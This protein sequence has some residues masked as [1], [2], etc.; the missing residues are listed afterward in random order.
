VDA[1]EGDR[2]YNEYRE[3]VLTVARKLWS[4]YGPAL[5]GHGIELDDLT[6]HAELTLLELIPKVDPTNIG[7][8]NYIYKSVEGSLRGRFV[9]GE[10]MR[11]SNQTPTDLTSNLAEPTPKPDKLSDE[12]L[13]IDIR[14]FDAAFCE[15]VLQGNKPHEARRLMGW[16]MA[17]YR[18]FKAR[19][20]KKLGA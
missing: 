13:F 18:A 16:N 2:L 12:S 5:S 19:I 8:Q 11:F 9:Q 7:L 1:K 17:Q 6:Q 4:M 3:T 10:I 15:L 20:G 14:G